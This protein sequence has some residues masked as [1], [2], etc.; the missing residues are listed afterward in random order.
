MAIIFLL[1]SI[2]VINLYSASTLKVESG[3]KLIP[4]F[5][6]QLAWGGIGCIGF[7][8]FFDL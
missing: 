8:L 2:G 5:K 4:Y 1:F 3:V 7:I 6:K